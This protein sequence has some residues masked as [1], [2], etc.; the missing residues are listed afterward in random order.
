MED[1]EISQF[2]WKIET[3]T[4]FSGKEAPFRGFVVGGFKW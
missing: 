1:M 3:F 4:R 2:T